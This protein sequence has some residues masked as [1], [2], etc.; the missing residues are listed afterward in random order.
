MSDYI[1][2]LINT[3]LH[4]P[5]TILPSNWTEDLRVGVLVTAISIYREWARAE[6]EPDFLTTAAAAIGDKAAHVH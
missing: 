4:E 1:E 3:A 6:L 5:H 2:R